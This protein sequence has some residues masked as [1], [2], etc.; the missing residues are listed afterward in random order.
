MHINERQIKIR[1]STYC[2]TLLLSYS[3]DVVCAN[4]RQAVLYIVMF[5]HYG[6]FAVLDVVIKSLLVL[7]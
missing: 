1:V 6:S 2:V 5:L 4:L 3:I 7:P